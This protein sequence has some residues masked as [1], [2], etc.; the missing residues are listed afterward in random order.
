MKKISH[1]LSLVIEWILLI[2]ISLLTLF[3]LLQVVCRFILKVSVSWSEEI[4][5]MTFVWMILLGAALGTK[6]WTHLSMELFGDKLSLESKRIM[7]LFILGFM[8]ILYCLFAYSGIQYCIKCIGKQAVTMAVPSNIVYCA[9]PIT[10]MIGMFFTVERFIDTIK[11]S[12]G[13][14]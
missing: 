12:G 10:C 13:K 3:T 8:F 4:V 1:L 5:R 6:E 14:A 11:G 7:D 2:L 9:I